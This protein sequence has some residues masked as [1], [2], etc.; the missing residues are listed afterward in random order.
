MR[1]FL[2]EKIASGGNGEVYRAHTI[3]LDAPTRVFAV[4]KLHTTKH[5][6]NPMLLHR[7]CAMIH[8][9]GHPSIPKVYALGQ[10]QYYEYLALE[11]LG[12][13]IYTP[14]E[15]PEGLTMRNLVALTC[16]MIDALQHVHSHHLVH[17][18]VKPANF[19]FERHQTGGIKLI[20]WGLAKLYRDPATLVHRPEGSISS[21]LGTRS[22][23]S[24]NVHYHKCPSRRDDMESLAYTILLLLCGGLPWVVNGIKRVG[25]LRE[26]LKWSGGALSIGNPAVFGDFLDYT[27]TLA[28]DEEPD[29]AGW[30]RRFEAMAP[31]LPEPPLYS[32]SDTSSR[33]GESYRRPEEQTEPANFQRPPKSVVREVLGSDDDWVATSSWPQPLDVPDEDLLG[34]ER[35]TVYQDLERIE[36]V[37]GMARPWVRPVVGTPA[38][39]I[40]P[41]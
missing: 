27:R 36:D 12:P 8:L 10:T 33:V 40:V 20:D 31:D 15:S 5:V 4:K 23:A 9:R 38:E 26:K 11:E 32:Y 18:D 21:L 34:N 14:L 1:L 6:R 30:R 29:Y 7:A 19:L 39:H 3:D 35:E 2:D 41:Y 17:C 37:P 25:V 22:F 13:D 24:I 28:F 16:Q